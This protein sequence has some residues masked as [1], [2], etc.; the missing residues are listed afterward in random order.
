MYILFTTFIT[1][2]E[3]F[4][5]SAIL[6][7]S[8]L[9]SMEISFYFLIGIIFNASFIISLKTFFLY[10]IYAFTYGH[11]KLTSNLIWEE[12][13]NNFKAIFLYF[14]TSL[15]F[16]SE[17]HT[18]K[19]VFMF[20][21]F[22][23]LM[24]L[25]SVV[26]N[27]AI[28]IIFWKTLSR[29]T[30][31]IGDCKEAIQFVNI[32][33]NNR[34]SLT[35]VVGM[36]SIDKKQTFDEEIYGTNC[37]FRKDLLSHVYSYEE[38]DAVLL[39]KKVSQIVVILPERDRSLTDQITKDINGKA[40]HIKF[41]LDGTGIVTFSSQ[42][43]D[44]DGLILVSTSKS[45]MNIF[46]LFIKRCIDIIASVI[47]CLM[48]IPLAIMIKY[49]YVKAGDQNP[50]IFTQERIG[51]D[52]KSIKIYKFR[53]MV[54]NAEQILED[55]MEKDQNI[56]EEYLTNKKLKNDPRVTSIG[57]KL[58]R[59]SLDEFPQFINVLKGEMALVGPRPY[60]HREKEDMSIYYDTIVS[61]KPGIT[62]MWQANG[63]SDVGFEERCKLDDYYY[64]N[65]NVMLD[66]IIIYKTVRSVVY[67]KGAM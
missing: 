41:Y 40:P 46:D 57:D 64:K 3:V 44:Y 30:I 39:R 14:I 50:I 58:R 52:G 62:G 4:K 31:V 24:F 59:T 28:R 27:R 45:I 25:L 60:L 54:P 19:R 55:L 42:V 17:I 66:F 7:V 37:F 1:R 15:I 21:C 22:S 13:K 18:Y 56:K 10:F 51:K 11:Y 53:T 20:F 12:I 43:K 48:V 26:F 65:W 29:K 61:C 9:L 67:G 63:R 34:F 5:M 33:K 47:G 23:I 36:V 49:K 6:F 38:L 32:S 35:N 8:L 16:V 2:L